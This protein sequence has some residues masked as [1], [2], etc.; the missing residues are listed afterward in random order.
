M[1]SR[2]EMFDGAHKRIEKGTISVIYYVASAREHHDW[3][4]PQVAFVVE[5][6]REINKKT[7]I[8]GNRPIDPRAEIMALCGQIC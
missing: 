1:I 4:S 2:N 8:Y 3:A 5:N 6:T 7:R